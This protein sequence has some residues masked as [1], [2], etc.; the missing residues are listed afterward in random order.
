[1]TERPYVVISCA[2]SLD[3]YLDDASDARLVLSNDEDFDHVDEVRAGVDAILV[4]ANTVRQD[5]PRLLIRAPHR[6]AARRSRGLPEHPLKV[7]I[8][9]TGDLDPAARFFAEGS[10]P[11]L[12]YA[13]GTAAGT[14]RKRLAG[15]ATVVD[16]DGLDALLGDLAAR[17]VGRLLVEGGGTILTQLLAGGLADELR[18]VIAPLLVG[19]SAAPRF[20]HDGQFGAA[21]MSLAEVRQLGDLAVLRYVIT[22]QDAGG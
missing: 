10:A 12:V 3:G 17:G 1:M 11:R 2:V 7:T 14:L 22:G 18:L 6:R 4:G 13:S 16:A 8:T 21:R 9:S 15:K 19:D 5:N 20:V